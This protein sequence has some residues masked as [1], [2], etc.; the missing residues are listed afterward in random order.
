M[1]TAYE[2]MVGLVLAAL[3][4]A[5]GAGAQTPTPPPECIAPAKPGGGFDLTCKLVQAAL[6]DAGHARP[7]HISYMPGGVG[8]I[9]YDTIITKRPAEAQTLVAFSSGSL[10]NLA[11]GR[12]GRHAMGDV[13][14]LAAV[15]ADYGI[16]L[17]SSRSPWQTLPD[18]LAALKANPGKITF[19]GG[20]TIGSQDW[21]KSALVAKAAGVDYKAMRFVAFEG[22]GEATAALKAGHVQV[23]AGDA[24]EVADKL[25]AQGPFRVLAVMAERRL[26]GLLAHVPTAREQGADMVWPSVRGLY[27][28]PKVSEA[29]F[30]AW[31]TTFEQLMATPSFDRLRAHYGLFPLQ[32][33]G[34]ALQAFL[35]QQSLQYADMAGRFGLRR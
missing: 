20:G 29:A 33:T 22:G 18:L 24:S 13:R 15:G 17:V 23:Y 14:W 9:A 4:F 12:F 35:E 31:R 7:M 2:W 27:M 3:A 21:V 30:H 26:P 25:P 16:V 28:G 6:A 32:M 1:R 5:P 34:P 10:L 19:A 8:A 11:N